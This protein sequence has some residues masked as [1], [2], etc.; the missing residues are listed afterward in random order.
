MR[1]RGMMRLSLKSGMGAIVLILLLSSMVE[2]CTAQ[3]HGQDVPVVLDAAVPFY[4]H[5]AQLAHIDGVVRFQVSTEGERVV[6]VELLEGQPI[7]ARAARENI[8]TW[9]LKW[10]PRAKFEVAFHYELLPDFTCEPDSGTVVLH[11][12]L[13]V[14][15]RVKGI[16]TCDPGVEV[17]REKKSK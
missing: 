1:N 14:E 13:E 2:V 6:A 8:K 10:H 9:R 17:R 15:V 12:P 7:L 4:P 5:N 16:Q 3:E 11:L